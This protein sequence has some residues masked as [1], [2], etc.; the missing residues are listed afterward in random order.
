[1]LFLVT[2]SYFALA[3]TFLTAVFF[4][5]GGVFF[6]TGAFFFAALLG[7]AASATGLAFAEA[8]VR[9]AR[10]FAARAAFSSASNS[11]GVNGRA[12]FRSRSMS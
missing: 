3:A 9:T 1:M 5:T 2:S 10:V 7:S 11:A 4:F 6:V 8:L 12:D